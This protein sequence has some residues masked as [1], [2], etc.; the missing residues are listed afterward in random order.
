MPEHYHSWGILSFS[1]RFIQSLQY[2]H[3]NVAEYTYS[4]RMRHAPEECMY[5]HS[6]AQ[7]LK[8]GEHIDGIGSKRYNNELKDIIISNCI[9][10]KPDH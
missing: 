3:P 10:I 2:P 1:V 4:F 9:V 5:P 8:N 7:L 6:I